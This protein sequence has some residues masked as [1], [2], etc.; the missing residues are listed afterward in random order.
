GSIPCYINLPSMMSAGGPGFYGA[1][2]APFVIDSDPVQPDFQVKDLPLVSGISR[3]RFK[4]RQRLLD[5]L[6]SNELL[7]GARGR[8][9]VMGTYY[10]KAYDLITSK[11]ARKAFAIQEEPEEVRR[12][13]GYSSLGQCALLSRRLV[14]AGCRFVGVDHGSWDTHTSQFP[15][16]EKDLI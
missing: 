1:E 7:A 14:E 12:T 6:E 5:G 15:S 16:L 8:P 13:Y 4:L 3:D 10:E 9:Q 2:H 11:D